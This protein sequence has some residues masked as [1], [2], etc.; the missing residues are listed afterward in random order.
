MSTTRVYNNNLVAFIDVTIM[1]G[2][3][4]FL[5]GKNY[6]FCHLVWEW[7]YIKDYPILF[8]YKSMWMIEKD[9]GLPLLYSFIY[10][11]F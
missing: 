10:P 4:F 9:K 8:L 5:F 1:R 7:R 3:I 6:I 11:Y 2:D